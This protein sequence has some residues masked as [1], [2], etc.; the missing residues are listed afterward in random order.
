MVEQRSASTGMEQL[1]SSSVVDI[2][3][4]GL[5]GVTLEF[6][7]KG[8]SRAS[9]RHSFT[10][11]NNT[12]PPYTT[13]DEQTTPDGHAVTAPEGFFQTSSLF[14]CNCGILSLTAMV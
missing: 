2:N 8:P 9:S 4:A 5:I 14:M 10:K 1:T 13:G 6:E 3:L 12:T 11:A 7:A